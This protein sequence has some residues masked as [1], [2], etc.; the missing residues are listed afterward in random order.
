MYSENDINSLRA[1]LNG[2]RKAN[3]LLKREAEAERDRLRAVLEWAMY[4]IAEGYTY[5]DHECGYKLRP[6]TGYCEWC[7]KYA[8]ALTAME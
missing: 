4:Q 2:S 6:D 3:E 1:M 8:D 5:Q 7:E